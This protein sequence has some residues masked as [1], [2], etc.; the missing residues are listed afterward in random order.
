MKVHYIYIFQK[1]TS[2]S[3][4]E[5]EKKGEGD[6]DQNENQSQDKANIN[7]EQISD[8]KLEQKENVG[9]DS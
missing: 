1:I 5:A 4:I 6:Q 8:E 2:L 9:Q 3:S 7:E